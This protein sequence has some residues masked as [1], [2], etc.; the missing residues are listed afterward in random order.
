MER[1]GVG[2]RGSARPARPLTPSTPSLVVPSPE[3]SPEP[4][5]LE[6]VCKSP[7]SCRS[8]PALAARSPPGLLV[9]RP[10][11]HHSPTQTHC[12]RRKALSRLPKLWWAPGHRHGC[13]PL[14]A[15]LHAPSLRFLEASFLNTF[16]NFTSHLTSEPVEALGCQDHSWPSSQEC[17]ESFPSGEA[18][19]GHP[20]T[21][22]VSAKQPSWSSDS[23]V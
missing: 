22:M 9:R 10:T 11:L 15:I 14:L 4:V 5:L 7:A 3:P 23:G 2:V 18:R 13:S 6:P 8:T 20:H 17:W 19:P 12:L 1:S 21:L 16:P